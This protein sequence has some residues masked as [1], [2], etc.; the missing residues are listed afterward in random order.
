MTL[1]SH[2]QLKEQ[3]NSPEAANSETDLCSLVDTEF[4]REI[5]K[6][7]RELRE[8]MKELRVGMK[9][10]AH[11]FRKELEKMSQEKSENPFAETPAE[12]KTPEEQNE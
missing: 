10:N 1:G 12:L 5:V 6:I 9:S 4:K 11:Y 2:S 7:L 8:N 3:E